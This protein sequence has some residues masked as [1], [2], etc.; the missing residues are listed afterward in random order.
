MLA[1]QVRAAGPNA[2]QRLRTGSVAFSLNRFFTW[3][4]LNAL[5]GC[6]VR[7]GKY[8]NLNAAKQCQDCEPGRAVREWFLRALVC[9]G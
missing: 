9:S 1:G 4:V 6:V 7:A 8:S 5:L 2:L 3:H